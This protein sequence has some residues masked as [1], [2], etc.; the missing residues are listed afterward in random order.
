M[1]SLANGPQTLKE[2]DMI[3]LRQTWWVHWLCQSKTNGQCHAF[4][5]PSSSRYWHGGPLPAHGELAR[6]LSLT[7]RLTRAASPLRFFSPQWPV[8]WLSPGSCAKILAR[9]EVCIQKFGY[10]YIYINNHRSSG[11][12][13]NHWSFIATVLFVWS[14][15][16]GAHASGNFNDW[17]F[18]TALN[19][20]AGAM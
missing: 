8:T 6:G 19:C 5:A 3:N 17:P 1:P 16:V 10:I 14:E 9:F 7:M 13:S 4:A 11:F 2:F 15:I 20:R 18:L 12:R